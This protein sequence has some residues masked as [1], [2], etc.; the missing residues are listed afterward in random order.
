MSRRKESDVTRADRVFHPALTCLVTV[1]VASCSL[2]R[3]DP[4][5][6]QWQGR[7]TLPSCG[8]VILK[9]G[10][11]LRR[12]ARSEL[13]CLRTALDSEQGAELKVR[14]GTTEGDP[15]TE[16]HRVTPTGATEI[17]VDATEDQFSDRKW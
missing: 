6:D 17:Y 3:S 11:T 8:S 1:T 4:V 16:Y 10:E 7:A 15:I 13:T 9:Q 12:Y 2:L 5:R 14:S